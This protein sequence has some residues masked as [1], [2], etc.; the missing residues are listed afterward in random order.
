M[1]FYVLSWPLNSGTVGD[2]I[3]TYRNYNT[4]ETYDVYLV[5]DRSIEKI[6][7]M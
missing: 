5:L 3:V 4:T 7:E 6:I 1:S 2:L